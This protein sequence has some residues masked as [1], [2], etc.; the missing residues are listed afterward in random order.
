MLNILTTLCLLI[1]INA[2]TH[3]LEKAEQAFLDQKFAVALENYA[4]V[5]YQRDALEITTNQEKEILTRII[6]AAWKTQQY[7][8]VSYFTN[9]LAGRIVQHPSNPNIDLNIESVV[10]II[11]VLTTSEKKPSE[12]LLS[13]AQKPFDEHALQSILIANAHFNNRNYR[14]F[15]EYYAEY[16]TAAPC[17]PI[18]VELPEL[19]SEKIARNMSY[20]FPGLGQM[21]ANNYASGI[22]AITLSGVGIYFT[23]KAVL[24][25]RVI[26]AGL[27]GFLL[28]YRYYSGNIQSAQLS[29]QK[30]NQQLLQQHYQSYANSLQSELALLDQTI[31]HSILH[32]PFD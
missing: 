4:Y 16:C 27:I 25:D 15:E 28:F 10:R 6:Y 9:D 32:L 12:A 5:Y 24:E 17:A 31:Y 20:I 30:H 14:R 8:A 23:G 22:G 29:V 19:K 11:E 13:I 26:D 2:N 7:D 21:Y 1:S 3:T 18:D